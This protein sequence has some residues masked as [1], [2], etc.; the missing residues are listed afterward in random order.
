MQ[1]DFSLG[2]FGKV[3]LD[4]ITHLSSFNLGETNIST[5]TKK[6]TGGIYN[7]L[8]ANLPRI[9]SYC[10]HDSEVEAFI[11]SESDS[12]KRS[13]ILHSF[14]KYKKPKINQA[15]LNWLHVA[16][17]DDLCYPETLNNVKVKFSLDFCTLNPREQYL[18]IINKA[19]LIFD[20]RERKD[21]YNSIKTK[22]PLILHDK[23]GCEC[24]INGEVVS[25]GDTEPK[26]NIH[27]NGA[28]DIYSGIFIQN[29]YNNGLDYAVKLTSKQTTKYLINEKT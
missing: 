26:E 18:D 3:Y 4:T 11:I 1:T 20:S 19:S 9:T 29:Y 2:L 16:Y 17:I 12:S 25:K 22:T 5:L 7:I 23:Y 15:L 6:T 28:G 8:N 27:V 10:F 14:K 13:S 24:I 21:L